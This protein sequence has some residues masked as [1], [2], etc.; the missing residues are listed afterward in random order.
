MTL[1]NTD[2]DMS[3]AQLIR[4]CTGVSVL[5]LCHPLKRGKHIASQRGL[6]SVHLLQYLLKHQDNTSSNCITHL[7]HKHTAQSAKFKC[8]IYWT[9]KRFTCFYFPH[10]CV[11]SH[12]FLCRTSAMLNVMD[13]YE[14]PKL[15]Y[16]LV[17][18]LLLVDSSNMCVQFECF[19]IHSLTHSLKFTGVERSV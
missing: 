5:A 3:S 8:L 2:L 7:T 9:F 10:L 14:W 12:L 1:I 6:M 15:K 16:V 19:A 13:V 4:L 11:R 17:L 18:V